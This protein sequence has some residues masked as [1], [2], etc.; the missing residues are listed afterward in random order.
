MNF[1]NT[2]YPFLLSFGLFCFGYPSSIIGTT[3]AQ[4][5]FLA[6]MKL[7]DA[8]TVNMSDKADGLI[9][10]MNGVYQ[11]RYSSPAQPRI[12]NSLRIGWSLFRS[13]LLQLPYG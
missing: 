2:L 1:K 13:S 8:K 5:T 12:V 9:G 3:L 6:D 10:A 11:V 4:P 7:V